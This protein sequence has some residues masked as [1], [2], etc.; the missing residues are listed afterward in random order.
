[1]IKTSL[2]LFLLTL[3]FSM[4][5]K[6][7][8]KSKKIKITFGEIDQM[9]SKMRAEGVNTDTTM[10]Y[11]YFFTNGNAEALKKV[12]AEL[13]LKKFQF[14]EIYQ[15][16][17]KTFWLHLKRKEIHHSKTLFEL[18]KELYAIAEKYRLNSYDGFDVG[19][20][21]ETKAI[22]R[23]TYVVPEEFNAVDFIKDGYPELIVG[24]TA[25]D[26]FPH[27][28]E[29]CYFV[30]VSCHYKIDNGPMLPSESEL[31]SLDRFETYVENEFLKHKI[32]EYYIFC[33]TYKG[34]RNVFLVTNDRLAANGCMA[35]IKYSRTPF[36]FEFEIIKDEGWTLYTDMRVK[37]EKNKNPLEK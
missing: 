23:D 12:A 28:H 25:F 21:D 1:M 2:L 35:Q 6:S 20:V 33:N 36:P 27:K 11:G 34:L 7:Q 22:E 10:L 13:K 14:V 16:T 3:I 29:F 30:K 19:N 4:K 15:D 24:N 26:R 9:F 17:A 32:K 5:A 37:F 31:D 18:D 8:T